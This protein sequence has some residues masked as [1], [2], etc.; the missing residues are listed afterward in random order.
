MII[1]VIGIGEVGSTVVS[2]LL[3]KYQNTVL[4]LIDIAQID[5]RYLDLFHA[6]SFNNNTVIVNNEKA[7]NNSDYIIYAAGYSNTI[8]QSRN[9]VAKENK[10]LIGE[11]FS[12]ITPKA[13][14][15]II[16]VTNPVE[17]VA[18]WISEHYDHK[19][20]VLGSGTCLDTYRLNYLLSKHAKVPINE[21]ESLVLGEH[22]DN[23]VPVYSVSSIN[24]QP[25]SN[26]FSAKELEDISNELK[27]SARKIRETETATKYGIAQ[28]VMH[29]LEWIDRK[30]FILPVSMPINREYKELL[31]L[32]EDIFFSQ[33][34]TWLGE[35][36]ITQPLEFNEKEIGELKSAYRSIFNHH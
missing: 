23:M 20:M 33:P 7:L 6:G 3:Q 11:I 14:T 27:L 19:L 26:Y 4:N 24:G 34:C 21:V 31:D 30:D 29:I 10:K 22:G 18:Q 8:E 15:V 9:S 17:L 36:L 5:G 32:K 1:S 35:E 2:L 25:V 12:Q 13:E 28:C 16:A